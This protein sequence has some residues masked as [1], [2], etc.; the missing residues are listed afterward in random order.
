MAKMWKM[1]PLEIL[2]LDVA[3]FAM[4]FEFTVAEAE[5]MKQERKRE[6]KQE[7]GYIE[8][9]TTPGVFKKPGGGGVSI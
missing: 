1:N 7:K 8:S 9:P 5:D 6:T 2:D 3:D 4:L